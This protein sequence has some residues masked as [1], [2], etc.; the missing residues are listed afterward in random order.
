MET[1]RPKNIIID[2][3]EIEHPTIRKKAIQSVTN[4]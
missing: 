2:D 1:I 4:Q 3:N